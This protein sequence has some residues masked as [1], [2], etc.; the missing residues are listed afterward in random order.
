MPAA[1]ANPPCP[2]MRPG[3]LERRADMPHRD[4]GP[5]EGASSERCQCTSKTCTWGPRRVGLTVRRAGERSC[6][7]AAMKFGHDLARSPPARVWSAHPKTMPGGLMLRPCFHTSK[8]FDD[9]RVKTCRCP[10]IIGKQVV[11]QQPP[12]EEYS[13]VIRPEFRVGDPYF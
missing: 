8:S 7:D 5:A 11:P 1:R 4:A 2:H 6:D 12:E 9:Q 10:R 3:A 13:Y